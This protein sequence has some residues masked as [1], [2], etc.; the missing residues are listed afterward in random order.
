ME[1]LQ[2]IKDEERERN[3]KHRKELEKKSK[4]NQLV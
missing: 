2:R 4:N 3:A 1:D